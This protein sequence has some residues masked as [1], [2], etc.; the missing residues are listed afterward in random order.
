VLFLSY[1]VCPLNLK[2]QNKTMMKIANEREEMRFEELPME[3]KISLKVKRIETVQTYD[4]DEEFLKEMKVVWNTALPFSEYLN[5]A[6]GVFQQKEFQV[7]IFTENFFKDSWGFNFPEELEPS[8]LGNN[9]EKLT[10]FEF[11]QFSIHLRNMGGMN[12]GVI[13]IP[14]GTRTKSDFF[15]ICYSEN[16]FSPKFLKLLGLKIRLVLQCSIH[17]TLQFRK[18]K[19]LYAL[20]VK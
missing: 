16:N 9:F 8:F 13:Y 20:K 14:V 7:G 15:P 1:D 12:G 2:K 17:P 18:S 3:E 5:S 19:R 6:G 4:F 11:I 10:I